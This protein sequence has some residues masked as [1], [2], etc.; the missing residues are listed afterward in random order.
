MCMEL[1]FRPP[2]DSAK[3]LPQNNRRQTFYSFLA[4]GARKRCAGSSLKTGFREGRRIERE[5]AEKGRVSLEFEN[6]FRGLRS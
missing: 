3:R 1:R 6:L 2:K 5:G 4:V